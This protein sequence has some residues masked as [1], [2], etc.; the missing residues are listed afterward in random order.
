MLSPHRRGSLSAA[1]TSG[2]ASPEQQA[3]TATT[4]TAVVKEVEREREKEKEKDSPKQ[5]K[6][7]IL[8]RG[9][10]QTFFTRRGPTVAA[11]SLTYKLH[12]LVLVEE[13]RE[14]CA[15]HG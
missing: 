6:G 10:V 15:S 7:G 11:H 1:S 3:E 14:T 2:P 12:L 8:S 9:K 4:A 5:K 13:E